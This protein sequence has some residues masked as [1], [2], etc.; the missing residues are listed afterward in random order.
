MKAKE[1]ICPKTF[2]LTAVDPTG[3]GTEKGGNYAPRLHSLDG[4]R[5]GLVWNTKPNGDV[6]LD[7]GWEDSPGAI[8]DIE[9][10]PLVHIDPGG[11]NIVWDPTCQGTIGS[12]S[13]RG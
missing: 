9:S 11:S 5:M 4:K 10:G 12:H 8:P 6:L 1:T 2:V 3:I 7:G 13:R